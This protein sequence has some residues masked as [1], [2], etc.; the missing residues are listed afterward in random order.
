M[1]ITDSVSFGKALKTMRKRKGYTQKEL[2]EFTGYSVSFISGV[3]RGKATSEIGKA[4]RLAMILGLDLNLTMRGGH[5]GL[6]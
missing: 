4:L 1:K 3:E 2:S 5:A 6:Y